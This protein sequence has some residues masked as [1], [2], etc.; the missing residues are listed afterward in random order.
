MVISDEQ[1]AMFEVEKTCHICNET[2]GVDRVRDHDHLTGA[3]RGAAHNKCNLAYHFSH[4]PGVRKTP[5]P[6]QGDQAPLVTKSMEYVIPV[7]FHNLRG[8]D[9]HLLMSDI[10]V[11]KSEKL[12]CIPNNTERYL[13][14]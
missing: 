5:V 13:S 2:L 12:K 6:E 10:G 3:Y 8:Y 14:R 9:C 4:R 7:V 1:S 11:Y